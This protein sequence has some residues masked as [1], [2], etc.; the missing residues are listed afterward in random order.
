MEDGDFESPPFSASTMNHLP[1]ILL[2]VRQYALGAAHQVCGPGNVHMIGPAVLVG[3]IL[4][5]NLT[6]MGLGCS[7][8]QNGWPG[9]SCRG[10]WEGVLR[11]NPDVPMFLSRA[12]TSSGSI[13]LLINMTLLVSTITLQGSDSCPFRRV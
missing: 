11:I 3:S 2:L 5:V 12:L 7:N 10:G 8:R 4:V 9:N 1:M 6:V 13:P